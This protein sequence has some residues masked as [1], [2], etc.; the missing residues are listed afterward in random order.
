MRLFV[1]MDGTLAKWNTFSLEIRQSE[2]TDAKEI[3]KLIYSFLEKENYYYNLEP[4][5][6]VVDAINILNQRDDIDVYILSAAISPKAVKDK[7]RWID[8]Y[9]PKI[10]PKRRIYTKDGDKKTKYV[11]LLDKNDYLL[12]DYNKNLHEWEDASAGKAIKLLNK[13]NSADSW[14]KDQIRY[15][16]SP[17]E[18]ADLIEGIMIGEKDLIHDNEP[19]LTEDEAIDM[20]FGDNNKVCCITDEVNIETIEEREEDLCR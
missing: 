4:N 12:D 5:K 1:D 17:E 18:I 10:E 2:L 9:L 20:I 13:V 16:R 3:Q 19:S 8:K 6:N 7:D 11:D 15:D 14:D